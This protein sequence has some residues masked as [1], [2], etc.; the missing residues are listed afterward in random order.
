MA[1]HDENFR[2]SSGPVWFL[3]NLLALAWIT[4]PVPI[5]LLNIQW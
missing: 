3:V 1:N 4:M 2:D 5:A